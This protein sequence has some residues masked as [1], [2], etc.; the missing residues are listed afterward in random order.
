MTIHKF[1]VLKFWIKNGG[2]LLDSVPSRG[3]NVGQSN[4]FR[5]DPHKARTTRVGPPRQAFHLARGA[6]RFFLI[7]F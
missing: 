7:I 4:P 6:A 5:P 2:N 3:G 1:I